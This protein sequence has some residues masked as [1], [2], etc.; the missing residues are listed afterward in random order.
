MSRIIIDA[1][2]SGTS[3]GRYIDKLIEYLHQL[4]PVHQIIILTKPDRISFFNKISPNFEILPS[5]YKEF[6]FAE[7]FGF[8]KQLNYLKPDLVHFGMTQQPILYRG[9]TI[10]TIHDLTT[11]RFNN[12]AKNKVIFKIKQNIYKAVIIIASKKSKFILTPSNFVKKDLVHFSKIN[13]NKIIVTYEA[14]DKISEEPLAVENL[15]NSKFLL[16]VGRPNPHKNLE[17]LIKA[18][19]VLR[20]TYP[21]LL[22]VLAGKKDANYLKI[23]SNLQSD[24]KPFIIFTDFISDGQLRYLYE[25]CLAYIF[26]SLSEGFG[27]PGLEA[28]MHGAPVISSS[29]TCLPEIYGSAASYFNPLNIDDMVRSISLVLS[30]KN[31]R[32]KLIASGYS[33]VKKYSWQKTAEQTL[34][35]YNKA[36]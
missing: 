1:R 2:E 22:L 36:F 14:A 20:K 4:K 24:I 16:Y 12:P 26:P 10:T 23:E 34:A 5:P 6:S 31:I 9:K 19:E 15:I 29:N 35:I 25:N 28:M 3:T 17:R 7:Q 13:P 18:F 11:I 32:D 27:L 21:D 33:Q 30:D 8:K